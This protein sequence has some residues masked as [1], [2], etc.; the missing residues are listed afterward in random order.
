[1]LSA[2]S[3]V[4]SYPVETVAALDRVCLQAEK[5]FD[6]PSI[7]RPESEHIERADEAIAMAAIY[8]A[9]RLNVTAIASL[10]QSGSTVKWMSRANT[11]PPIYALTPEKETRRKL[12]LYRGVYP[13]PFEEQSKDRD[14]VLQAAEDELRTRGAVK[15]GDLMLLTIGEPIGQAGGTNTLKI[16]KVGG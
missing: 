5:D 7:R 3:A 9:D 12:T 4:G 13:F 1:M 14:F 11:L 16:V 6:N 2:E 10:T 15:N 8:T